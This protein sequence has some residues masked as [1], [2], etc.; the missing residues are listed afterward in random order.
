MI[1]A[2]R[3][4]LRRLFGTATGWTLLAVFSLVMSWR[5]LA[6]VEAAQFQL[7][8][9]VELAASVTRLV[10]MPVLA[11][12]ALLISLAGAFVALRMWGA[13][14]R[15][16]TDQW[17]LGFPCSSGTLVTAQ[18]LA[19]A[20]LLAAMAVLA[21]LIAASLRLGAEIDLGV[22]LS[23]T[24]GLILLGCF[25]VALAGFWSA[26]LASPVMAG[27][28][29]LLT[30][31]ALWAPDAAASARG[32]LLSPLRWVAI[33]RRLNPFLNGE[34]RLDDVGFF[35]VA[36]LTSLALWLT[37]IRRDAPAR[38]VAR[39]GIAGVAA[40]ALGMLSFSTAVSWDLTRTQRHT[41]A[42]PAREFLQTLE[43]PV[44]LTAVLGPLTPANAISEFAN[45]FQ[46]HYPAL[47][48][49]LIDPAADPEKALRLDLEPAE[50]QVGYG[51]RTTRIR[52]LSD[53]EFINAL[54]RLVQPRPARIAYAFGSGERDLRGEANH[55]WGRFGDEL[56]QLGLTPVPLDLVLNP[57]IP[58]DLDLMIV[59]AGEAPPLPGTDEALVD[60][61]ERDGSTLWWSGDV[62]TAE[63]YPELFRTLGL[64]A[65]PGTVVDARAAD[66]GRSDPRF[67]EIRRYPEHPVTRDLREPVLLPIATAWQTTSN[68]WRWSPI[69]ASGANSWN[70]TSPVAG[71]LVPDAADER[72]GPLPLIVAAEHG[73]QR[74]VVSGDGDFL[75]NRFLGNGAN[76]EL[77][78]RL[79]R[80]LLHDD[81]RIE[82]PVR[83]EPDRRLA[84]SVRQTGWLGAALLAGLPGALLAVGGFLSWRRRHA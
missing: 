75:S 26:A 24:L 31:I 19:N 8:Q 35:G 62:G 64:A 13:D 48:L 38:R 52:T 70:E 74:L 22:V 84:L 1:F 50:V 33:S 46:R 18:W 81:Q 28:L 63:A 36:T 30:L 40:A 49:D 47:S 43:E 15:R 61:V 71:T 25:A 21:A 7:E 78:V 56:A 68:S 9:Q 58:A 6:L 11:L 53:R 20:V 41:L 44:T 34:I 42:E 66:A 67:L 23:A 57:A 51:E 27:L 14:Q 17:L 39:L 80:W 45:R 55:D 59:A 10:V 72:P 82:L 32:D 29:T 79:V 37:C 16:G 73:G 69:V 83:Q 12:A 2:L 3:H 4:E 54:A 60:F 5:L 76:V 65:L 77:G